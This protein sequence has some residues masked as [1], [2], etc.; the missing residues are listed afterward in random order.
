MWSRKEVKAKGKASFKRSYWK[1]VLVALIIGIIGG[2]AGAGGGY[3]GGMNNF[4]SSDDL[5]T[6]KVDLDDLDIDFDGVPKFDIDKIDDLGDIKDA[7]NDT[8]SSSV[9]INGVSLDAKDFKDIDSL[10]DLNDFLE[11]HGAKPI[12]I[13][14]ADKE[15]GRAAAIAVF[16]IALIVF[17]V[18]LIISVIGF[19]MDVFLIKP[20]EFGCKRF[21]RKNLEEPA[22]LS[23][24]VF[25]FRSHYKNV[26]KLAFFYN[27]FITLWTLLFIVPGIIKSYS[28][29]LAPYIIGENPEMNWR[30]ALD[31]SARLMKGNKWRAFVYDLSFIGWGLLSCL[32]LGFLGIFFVNP[33]KNSSD[34]ALY[35][36]IRYGN[37]SAPVVEAA[38]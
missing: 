28:Y 8:A 29:R 6:V 22:K 38:A 27:L 17:F 7:V 34:A 18:C 31:E 3:Y 16:V 26:V 23:N 11:D 19:V 33:Y 25:A 24:I 4:S 21:F 32:T 36:A 9:M 20:I 12:D 35:E 1:A 14:E 37:Q 2:G 15:A 13:K 10:D 5:N 30:Q